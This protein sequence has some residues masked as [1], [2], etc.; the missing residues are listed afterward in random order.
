MIE[1]QPTEEEV[2]QL[3]ELVRCSLDPDYPMQIILKDKYKKLNKVD[4]L[5][6]KHKIK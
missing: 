4:K 3:R 6:N 2:I 5:I 1:D